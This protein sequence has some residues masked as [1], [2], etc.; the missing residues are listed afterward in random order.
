MSICW[1]PANQRQDGEE[2]TCAS[3]L[4]VEILRQAPGV[5]LLVTSRERLNVRGEWVY[6]VNGLEVPSADEILHTVKPET[7]EAGDTLFEAYS[8][9]TLFL[10][11]AQRL[12]MD[13]T[14]TAAEKAAIV[15]ICQLVQGMPLA[16]E[17]A[18]AWVRALSCR[19]IAHEIEQGL[20]FLETSL[21]DVPQRHRS[22]QAVFD[23]S[24]KRLNGDEQQ[25]FARC[26]V[27][28]GG[29]TREAATQVAGGSL[30]ILAALVDKS[31]LKRDLN[32]R[33]GMHELARQYAAQR[34]AELQQVAQT[35]YRH[36]T[37]FMQFAEEAERHLHSGRQVAHWHERTEFDKT[38]RA[39]L[40]WSLAGVGGAWVA[41]GRGIVGV[42]DEPGLC[43]R[44]PNAG[45]A[46]CGA[47]EAAAPTPLRAKALYTAGV[48]TMYQGRLLAARS[49][50][51]ETLP[52][53]GRSAQ[54][55][56]PCWCL[57]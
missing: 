33:Y 3:E 2:A 40:D 36:L 1:S 57:G 52:P 19:E 30:P 6:D 26:S 13:F 34:L 55:L 21:R 28:H 50:L 47:T 4:V 48:C 29:F 11:T 49:W 12:Q 53:A 8:A 45:G 41:H 25:V 5:T 51:T 39:G 22:L 35:R 18:A 17:L 20:G 42:L 37:F 46:F 24:W 56:N 44:R 54:V 16:L 32:G 38:L 10:Q 23:H 15:R 9:V 27:F 31:L 7:G 43:I 14:P